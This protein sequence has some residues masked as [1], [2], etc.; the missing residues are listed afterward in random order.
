MSEKQ[1]QNFVNALAADT[2][3]ALTVHEAAKLRGTIFAIED[4]VG[5]QPQV[6][7]PIT[8]HFSKNI[9]AREMFIPKG[10]LLV[11]KIHKFQ[12]MNIISQGH[13]SF[14]SVDGAVHV[15]APHSF[16]ASPGVKR[17]IYAHEDSVWTTIHGTDETDLKRIEAI[18]IAK[19]Y[20]EVE[21]IT[22]DE[23]KIIKEE[24]ERIKGE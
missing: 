15:K 19:S 17:V 9:Y 2:Q 18:F 6:E 4:F 5:K 23:L 3:G 13:V 12:N 1:L 22:E 21:T 8:H 7:F 20:D 11:G 14:F 24:I 16:V 10:S